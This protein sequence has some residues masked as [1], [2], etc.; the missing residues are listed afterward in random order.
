MMPEEGVGLDEVRGSISGL[1]QGERWV[2]EVVIGKML[3]LM[4]AGSRLP[5]QVHPQVLLSASYSP[6]S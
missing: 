3:L 4:K 5:E 6:G 1:P 2:D